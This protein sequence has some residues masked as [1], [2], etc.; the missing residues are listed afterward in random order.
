[1]EKWGVDIRIRGGIGAVLV[2]SSMLGMA[3]IFGKLAL[4]AGMD[5]VFLVVLRT[6]L[7][8]LV[9]WV[10]FFLFARK[11]LFIYPVGLVAC[12]AAGFINGLGSLAFYSS[13]NFLDASLAQLLYA[14]NPIMLAFLLRLDGQPISHLTA[15][16]LILAMPAV[17][18]ISAESLNGGSLWGVLL[19]LIG[20]FMYAL[21]LAVNQNALRD[22]PSPTV[23]LYTLTAMA[24][25]VVPS[26]LFLSTPPTQYPTE[27]WEGLAGL[28]V[29]TVISRLTL[30]IG[31]QR[32]GG[33]QSAL[34]G[35]MELVVSLAAAY[36]WLGERLT[37]TQWA[38]A[39]VLIISVGLVSVE[40]DLGTK[41]HV[42][43]GWLAW[44][45]S[46]IEQP[47]A[48]G[49][50]PS[51]PPTAASESAVGTNSP[52]RPAL[53][54]GEGERV[55]TYAELLAEAEQMRQEMR[56]VDSN[57]VIDIDKLRMTG[58][59][60]HPPEDIKPPKGETPLS[61]LPDAL[62][63]PSEAK[64]APPAKQSD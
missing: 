6:T 12:F 3:P 44:F 34:L 51:P 31:V 54:L 58:N 63:A 32:L 57:I 56:M 29:V 20:A 22:V 28:M 30:F 9:L 53:E 45:F 15:F 50:K 41:S 4:N 36:F 25:V 19:M 24:L 35:L 33:V 40:R 5:T 21:H 60:T 26:M 38:G 59:P 17:Y 7:A 23:T 18:L 11:Y 49:Y 8:A 61:H 55:P 43:T 10:T 39:T 2:S 46:V 62:P 42:S 16:R 27:A 48:F 47:L 37:P 14:T 13:L 1:M 52:Q 64:P